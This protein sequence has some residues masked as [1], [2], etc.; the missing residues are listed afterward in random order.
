MQLHYFFKSLSYYFKKI[1]FWKF[2]FGTVVNENKNI[3]KV[4]VDIVEFQLNIAATSYQVISKI[5][6][7]FEMA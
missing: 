4:P 3:E 6:T 7:K 2:R 1:T 5:V